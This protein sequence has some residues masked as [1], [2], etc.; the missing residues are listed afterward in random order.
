MVTTLIFEHDARR[1]GSAAH[2]SLADAARDLP[3]GSYT[4]L[5]TYGGRRVLRL[6]QHVTRLNESLAL[7]GRSGSLG[8]GQ[9]RA[10]VA[11]A[12]AQTRHPESRIRLT[13]APPRLFVS[14]EPFEPLPP[15]LYEKGVACVTLDVQRENPHAKDTRF[16]ATA[17]AAYAALPAGVHEGLLVGAGGAILEGL[18]SNFFALHRG[19]LRSEEQRALLGVTRSLVIEIATSVVPVSITA[20]ARDELEA[21]AEA[22]ITSVS[23]GILPVVAIDSRAVGNGQPGPLTRELMRRFVEMQ[24]RE[25][26]EV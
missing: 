16:I 5:R 9:V 22:F 26:E 12:L 19:I 17:A 24:E 13:Y 20:V 15:A 10:A 1:A 2:E 11:S 4:T 18:S 7:T 8:E 25:A 3:A 14:V 6:F 21:V 23:R